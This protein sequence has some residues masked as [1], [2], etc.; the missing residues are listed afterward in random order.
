[1]IGKFEARC[2]E[3]PLPILKKLKQNTFIA[4]MVQVAKEFNLHV[5]WKEEDKKT[6]A[7]KLPWK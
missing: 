7:L 4:N 2:A 6:P 1:M 3:V 5:F